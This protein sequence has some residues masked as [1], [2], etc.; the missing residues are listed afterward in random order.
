MDLLLDTQAIVWIIS[1]DPRLSDPARQALVAE[2]NRIFIS[3]VTAFEFADLEARGRFPDA[4]HFA[5]ACDWL[6]AG[7]L[8]FPAEAWSLIEALPM[9]HRDPVDRMVIAHA[10]HADLTLVTAD[11][12]MRE[13]P[14]KSLW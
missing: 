6:S 10:L 11:A 2:D 7:V 9:L 3:A 13:Y 12:V 8:D 1:N 5:D 14:V 4:V